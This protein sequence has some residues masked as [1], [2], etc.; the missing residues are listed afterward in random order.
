VINY[1]LKQE[2]YIEQY[3][4]M[5]DMSA[6]GWRQN[7]TGCPYCHD[8]RSKNPRSHFLFQHD[9]IGFQCFNCGGKH[10]FM[11]SNVKT[12]ANFIS[13]SAWKKVGAIL[14]ELKKDKIFPKS[15]L[16]DQEELKG[17]VE[18]DQEVNR[19]IRAVG[20]QGALSLLSDVY[21]SVAGRSGIL[22]S[23]SPAAGF[24][25]RQA[26]GDIKLVKSILDGSISP[27]AAVQEVISLNTPNTL[28]DWAV[29][30]LY[31]EAFGVK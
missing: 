31:N 11:G 26:Q 4:R 6:K 27:E 10:R 2:S 5:G 24:T 16:K 21:H 18:D 13:K 7:L 1:N 15:D 8:G 30:P 29:K 17:E 25:K 9:E 12:L 19:L 22:E 28:I 3:F 20:Q 23:V 14:L